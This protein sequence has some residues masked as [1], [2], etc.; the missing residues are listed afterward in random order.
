MKLHQP[1]VSAVVSALKDIFFGG[2]KADKVIERHL[3]NNKK[4]GSRDRR[5]FAETVYDM[6]RW[7]RKI[8]VEVGKEP[9]DNEKDLY[10]ALSVW[11]E[12][13][14]V[15]LPPWLKAA[16]KSLAGERLPLSFAVRES[17]PDW[18]DVMGRSEL[19]EQWEAVACAL[20]RQA[21]VV[22]RTNTLLTNRDSL[23]SRLLDEGVETQNLSI[24][25]VALVLT[26]RKNVFQT[27]CFKLGLFEVQ[28]A[29]SQCIAPLLEVE[30]GMRVVDACAGAGGKTLHIAALMRNKGKIIALD[31][32][33]A[34]L[35]EL[36]RRARRDKIDIIE[37]RE[38]SSGKVIKR[39][40]ESADRLLLDV[41][42]SG[43]GVL[44]RNPDTKWK[45][46][47]EKLA[48]L[49]RLQLEIL[50]GYSSIVRPGGT[51]VYSTCSILPSENEAIVDKFLQVNEGLW[52]VKFQKRW[53]PH[54]EG[55]DGFFAAVMSRS[56]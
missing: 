7:W 39:L 52:K 55:F 8:W 28:D 25:D 32:Y 14:G 44:R 23:R 40:R 15:E 13:N 16:D 26:E 41:P 3:K 6:V 42:C 2:F 12:Q 18:I 9:T 51:M 50:T 34:K 21:Q 11:L 54:V 35:A 24:N 29:V 22:L 53:L 47:Q 4:W 43:L 33:P 1:I 46:T 49:N 20:N 5:F 19:G 17:Y 30:S 36:M 27:Q 48:N 56:E 10:Q 38:I 31:I 45:L 37:P